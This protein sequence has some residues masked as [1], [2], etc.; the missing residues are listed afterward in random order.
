MAQ[1]K[2]K[3]KKQNRGRNI[4]L[5]IIGLIILFMVAIMLALK[6]AGVLGIG[7][8]ISNTEETPKPQET[9]PVVRQT[10]S[11]EIDST[12]KPTDK[13][14]DEPTKKPERTPVPQEKGDP[15]ELWGGAYEYRSNTHLIT[16][17]E[18]DA[19]SRETIK[20]IYWEV[21]ARHGYTFD[22]ELADYFE[23]NHSWYIPTTTDIQSVEASF[24]D[25]E[26][27]NIRTIYDYQ[28]EKGWR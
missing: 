11:P 4:I 19:L 3:K 13:P 12:P 2:K 17:E 15:V 23:T 5:S 27:R 1:K 26:K 18:L 6:L 28:K 25:I 9:L 14:T 8:F 20:H 21:Y 22:G 7:G 16:R 24:N 10:W